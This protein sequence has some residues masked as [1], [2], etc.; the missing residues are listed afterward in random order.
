LLYNAALVGD[1]GAFPINAY[2]DRIW[3]PGANALGFGPDVGNPHGWSNQDPLRGHGVWDVLYN[4]NQNLYN[5][6]FELFG[7]CSGS[8]VSCAAHA[9]LGKWNRLDRAA[10]AFTAAIVAANSVYW[11]SGG[12]D[13]GARYWYLVIL[14]LAWLS[15]RGLATLGDVLEERFADAT[16][17]VTATAGILV[18][19]SLA[20][21]TPWRAVAK[22]KDY[23]GYHGDFRRLAE[24]PS[25]AGALVLVDV[26]DET[27]YGLAFLLNDPRGP[28]AGP[29]FAW[30]RDEATEA[31]LREAFPDR[32]IVRM[33]GRVGATPARITGREGRSSPAR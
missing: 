29:V 30:R 20:V 1:P 24:S 4:A 2:L 16:L 15:L 25:L 32:S 12:S 13:Y 10:F 6:N 26:L 21:F 27:E 18:A 14:P 11:F 33:S 5:L 17:R 22:Y 19:I 31:R 7:W 28:G 3:Y 9:I 23:R 8:L